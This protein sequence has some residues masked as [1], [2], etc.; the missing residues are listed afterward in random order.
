MKPDE[1][2][3]HALKAALELRLGNSTPAAIIDHARAFEHYIGAVD[4]PEAGPPS[5]PGSPEKASAA[6]SKPR[7]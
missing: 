6:A 4:Y 5:D 3:V 1:A 7:R 2:R